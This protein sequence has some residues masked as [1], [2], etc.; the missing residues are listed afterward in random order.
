MHFIATV[1]TGFQLYFVLQSC[2]RLSQV[3]ISNV[4]A[5]SVRATAAVTA[6]AY[7]SCSYGC[8]CYCCCRRRWDSLI[9]SAA[10]RLQKNSQLADLVSHKNVNWSDSVLIIILGCLDDHVVLLHMTLFFS[11]FLIIIRMTLTNVLH[12]YLHVSIIYNCCTMINFE[13]IWKINRT[14]FE[15][16]MW[17]RHYDVK[18]THDTRCQS[19]SW[20][21]PK[22][23]H[24]CLVYHCHLV[25]CR[26]FAENLLF[27]CPLDVRKE[28]R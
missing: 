28:P 24:S 21:G 19:G 23:D 18:R 4:E 10:A 27:L 1:P 17:R 11:T 20:F 9:S 3:D 15:D 22:T 26:K 25:I 16:G 13:I 2:A 5:S 7:F 14:S 8:C 6:A 12:G